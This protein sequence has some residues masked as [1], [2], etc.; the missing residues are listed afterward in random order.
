MFNQLTCLCLQSRQFYSRE[1]LNPS[2]L[3]AALSAATA[4]WPRGWGWTIRQ[5]GRFGGTWNL[6]RKFR[7]RTAL[8]DGTASHS[9]PES[10]SARHTSAPGW[11]LIPDLI[12][13][14]FKRIKIFPRVNFLHSFFNIPSTNTT[15]L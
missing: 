9:K 7:N 11:I 4:R 8:P 13:Q 12:E 10:L 6:L 1:N 5:W 14:R 2:I 15:K 3:E